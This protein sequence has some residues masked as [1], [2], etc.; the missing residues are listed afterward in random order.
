MVT[1]AGSVVRS[2]SSIY[3]VLRAACQEARLRASPA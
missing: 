1:R 2:N 3:L